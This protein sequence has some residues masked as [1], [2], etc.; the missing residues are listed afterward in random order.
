M[1]NPFKAFAAEWNTNEPRDKAFMVA[2][3]LFFLAAIIGL[4]VPIV[5]QVP[6]AVIAAYFFSKGSPRLH[7]WIRNNKHLGPPVK[8]WEEHRV[9]RPKLK[10]VSTLAMLG[11]AAIGHWQL[12]APWYWIIDGV[13]ALSI[14]FML[15]RKSKP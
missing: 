4:F 6:F 3:G 11:G 9:V 8:D 2:G 14:V 12:E 13:F 5:P 10:L 15:T 7:R 1:A